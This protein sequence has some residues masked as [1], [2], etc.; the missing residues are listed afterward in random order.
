MPTSMP[1][2]AVIVVPTSSAAIAVQKL[3]PEARAAAT[4]N[5]VVVITQATKTPTVESSPRC[6]FSGTGS[7]AWS[8]N[9]C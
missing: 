8:M 7:S 6:S 5:G 2:V 9:R 1:T 4:R 3:I